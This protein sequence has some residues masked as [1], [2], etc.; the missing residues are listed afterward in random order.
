M[1]KLNINIVILLSLVF[2]FSACERELGLGCLRPDGNVETRILNFGD[3]TKISIDFATVVSFTEGENH[4]LIIEASGNIIDR[5]NSDS[6]KSG[7]QLDLEIN[8][9]FNLGMDDEINV[10]ITLPTL[11]EIKVDGAAEIFSTNTLTLEENLSIIINGAAEIDFDLDSAN[12]IMVD[13]DGASQIVLNGT[14][15]GLN[16]QSDG[17]SEID[18]DNLEVSRVDID[19]D[20]GGQVICNLTEELVIQLSGLA[21]VEARGTASYQEITIDGGGNVNNFNLSANDT[22]I[23]IDGLGN[24]EVTCVNTLNVNIDGGG[25]V[26]YRGNPIVTQNIDGLGS[27]NSCN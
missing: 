3:F 24:A 7:D 25:N 26:C 21:T 11:E 10:F 1:K 18:A 22:E 23:E 14:A 4:E 19:I 8:G 15:D 27:V 17:F 9:C 20:G 2:L 12:E 16:I 13:T 6:R 5:L